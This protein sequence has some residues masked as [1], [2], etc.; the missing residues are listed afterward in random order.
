MDIPFTINS[1]KAAGLTQAQIAGEIGCS[2]PTVSDLVS[3]KTGT[4][5][6]SYKVVEGLKRLAKKYKVQTRPEVK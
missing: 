1:L 4:T 5:R 2:Q 3:G 6:P